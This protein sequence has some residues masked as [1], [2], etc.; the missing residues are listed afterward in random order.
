MARPGER[1]R[2][3]L[4]P[5]E[6]LDMV[7]RPSAELKQSLIQSVARLKG[8]DLGD[9]FH[10][11]Y[12]V[13]G[14]FD[15]NAFAENRIDIL[16]MRSE[17]RDSDELMERL[18]AKTDEEYWSAMIPREHFPNVELNADDVGILDASIRQDLLKHIQENM[19]ERL[20]FDRYSINFGRF[21][22]GLNI[23][24]GLAILLVITAIVAAVMGR[25]VWAG[26]AFSFAILAPVLY[27]VVA[28]R[29]I[30]FED[31]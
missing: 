11:V 4:A 10:V 17:F 15:A 21:N 30:Q 16:A 29:L 5:A 3:I 25:F 26:I 13:R 8:H 2:Y 24:L 23:F 19:N 31:D 12:R 27:I 6:R 7:E 14:E 28:R 22:I 9:L 1:W 18:K 20:A